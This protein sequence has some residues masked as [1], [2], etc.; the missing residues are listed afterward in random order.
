MEN[1]TATVEF[2]PKIYDWISACQ[3]R[4]GLRFSEV[5]NRLLAYGIE[6][7]QRQRPL[8][9]REE[10]PKEQKLIIQCVVQSLL[11]LQDQ[12]SSEPKDK[13]ALQERAKELI[14][15]TL[16]LEKSG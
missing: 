9:E 8:P 2:E 4:Q 7:E 3:K 16:K 6:V 1:I 13:A 11:M 14:H 5:M 10:I 15:K 12:Y